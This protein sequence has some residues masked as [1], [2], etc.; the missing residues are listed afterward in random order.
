MSHSRRIEV[1][2]H[3]TA[4]CSTALPQQATHTNSSDPHCQHHACLA[5][6]LLP[7]NSYAQL[8]SAS[9]QLAGQLSPSLPAARGVDGPRI[10]VY[11]EPG[12]DYVAATWASWLAGA[13]AVPLA[14]S[15]PPHE[16]QYVM[17][18]AG[19]CKVSW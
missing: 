5:L 9:E 3:C 19:V 13:I 7:I 14:V 6:R 11:A 16:L 18:D 10:G 8:L 1:R 12:S 4:N 15:H 17:Q 2:A